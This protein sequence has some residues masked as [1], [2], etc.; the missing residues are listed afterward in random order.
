MSVA[1]A[2]RAMNGHSNV[3]D[4]LRQKVEDAAR[5][6]RYVPHSGA[7]SLTRQKNDAVGVVLP[8]LF[9]EFFSEIVRGIDSVAQQ[10]GMQLLLA[11][12]HGSAQGT[13]TAIRAMNGRV[14][15]LLVMPPE[16]EPD[17]LSACLPAYLPTVVL[18]YEPGALDVPSVAIDNY[19]GARAMVAHLVACGY[20]N[21]AHIAGPRHNRDAQQRCQG[22][23]DAMAELTGERSPIIL[24]GDFSEEA[25][26]E[27]ARVIIAGHMP[28]D[29]VF[30][31][32]DMMAVGCLGVLR[33]AGIAVPQQMAVAG[34]DDIP[35]A[36][37]T[38]P[39]LTTMEVHIA[40]LGAAAMTLLLQQLR[41]DNA[42]RQSDILLGP[43]L[44]A[45]HSTHKATQHQVIKN[46]DG[47]DVRRTK[48][49]SE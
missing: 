24:P 47:H 15:G 40:E 49:G 41:D 1:S 2:S 9:G 21:I 13:A 23:T 7:R 25:G 26:A 44:I 30:A 42:P 46:D 4:S 22:F 6:L 39:S 14:D 28:V 3:T 36:R 45:R 32:N 16:I 5:A 37:H 10:A 20:R 48:Q 38:A 33:D 31:A 35:L 29:A 27:A 19:S 17:H 12:M 8:D 11:N 43:A 34:F 18:N